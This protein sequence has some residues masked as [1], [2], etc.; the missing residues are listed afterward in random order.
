[1]NR[2]KYYLYKSAL[3]IPILRRKRSFLF[4][5]LGVNWLHNNGSSFRIGNILLIGDYSHLYLHDNAE[6]NTGCMIVSK[7]RIEIG[8]NSTLAYGVT[9]LTSANPNGPEN[10][11]SNI[12]P[13]LTAP[14]LIGNN[15]WVGANAT[16]L[17]GVT[18]GDYSVIA[19]GSVVTAD[20]PSGV[21]VAGVPATVRK[22]LKKTL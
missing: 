4:Q 13:E 1:M 3:N 11:L 17:P 22:N 9:V 12:Y 14:V 2:L 10:L 20:V 5:K 18:I 21:M 7:D 6:I 16:I 15:V 8:E 19:A